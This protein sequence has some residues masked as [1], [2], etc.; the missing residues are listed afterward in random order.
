[1]TINLHSASKQALPL[2]GELTTERTNDPTKISLDINTLSTGSSHILDEYSGYDFLGDDLF[3]LLG[4]L[5]KRTAQLSPQTF[6]ENA[7]VLRPA[8][9]GKSDAIFMT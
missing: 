2:F 4:S 1:V 6:E 8:F 5:L 9:H 3:A 7:Q